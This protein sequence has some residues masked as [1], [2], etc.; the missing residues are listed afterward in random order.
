MLFEYEKSISFYKTVL[1][2][3]VCNFESIACIGAHYFYRDHPEVALK[4]YKRL[5]ELGINSGEVWNNLGLCA[6]YSGQYDFCI[7][8]FERGLL[9]ADEE[10]SSEIWY[11]ISHVAIGVGNMEL[12]YHALK[13]ALQF[14][15]NHF[16]AQNNLG[17]L[18]SRKGN[19]KEAYSNYDVARKLTDYSYEPHYNYAVVN[20]KNG[21][22]EKS[23]EAVKKALGIYPEHFDSL[24]LIE[25]IRKE[26]IN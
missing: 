17:V 23:L 12:A 25:F 20:Y 19:S 24:E 7:S 18:E 10:I 21:N 1:E 8:C 2:K 14:N 4:Y 6:Y 9:V 5:F 26:I 11:N 3:D 22:I 16:E 13:V 15:K